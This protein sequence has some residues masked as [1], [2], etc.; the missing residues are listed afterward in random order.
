MKPCDANKLSEKQK[1][2]AVNSLFFITEKE[3]VKFRE[4]KQQIDG[5]GHRGWTNEEE[6]SG[7]TVTVELVALSAIIDDKD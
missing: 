3:M 2:Q 6:V 4:Q 5:C 7:P 1:R